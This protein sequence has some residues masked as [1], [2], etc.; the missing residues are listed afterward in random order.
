MDISGFFEN[1]EKNAAP[2]SDE[3]EWVKVADTAIQCTSSEVK[4]CVLKVYKCYLT[5]NALRATG[6]HSNLQVRYTPIQ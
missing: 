2:M 1:F 6:A 4:Q 3:Y 5:L